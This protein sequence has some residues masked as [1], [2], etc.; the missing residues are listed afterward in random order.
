MCIYTRAAFSFAT[1]LATML[2]R[3]ASDPLQRLLAGMLLA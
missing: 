2:T 1:L 3:T